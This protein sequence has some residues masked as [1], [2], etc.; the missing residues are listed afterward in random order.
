MGFVGSIWWSNPAS[1]SPFCPQERLQ[2]G[3]PLL[4]QSELVSSVSLEKA[5]D[6]HGRDCPPVTPVRSHSVPLAIQNSSTRSGTLRSA[7]AAS[8]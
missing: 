1:I 6:D 4:G 8:G 5:P 3:A 2:R 7:P